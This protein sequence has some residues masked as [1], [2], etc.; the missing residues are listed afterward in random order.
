MKK[1]SKAAKAV[2]TVAKT[3]TPKTEKLVK[4]TEAIADGTLSTDK[5]SPAQNEVVKKVA[6][7]KGIE[8]PAS[9]LPTK[10]EV[11]KKAKKEAAAAIP[12][13][14]DEEID[15]MVKEVNAV[16]AEKAPK[17]RAPKGG[18]ITPA[19]ELTNKSGKPWGKFGLHGTN[20]VLEGFVAGDKVMFNLKG[21]QTEGEF[22]HFHI[23]NHS[24]KGYLVIKV[25]K[26]IFERTLAKV[27]KV[28][29][30]FV[31]AQAPA[32]DNGAPLKKGVKLAK[33]QSQ[34]QAS[35]NG[36]PFKKVAKSKA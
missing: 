25:G 24:P 8:L 7:I 6:A 1:T 15:A 30:P 13:S 10:K 34:A 11:I 3:A 9:T 36:A 20:Q 35:D 19:A 29:K 28:T 27:T 12:A 4:V 32:S 18:I 22:S 33:A 14:H 23:N 17:R 16:A 26:K 21:V 31:T 2:A 5:L